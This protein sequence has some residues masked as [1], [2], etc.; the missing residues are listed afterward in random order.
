MSDTEKKS[1]YWQIRVVQIAWLDV[2]FEKPLTE[3]EAVEAFNKDEYYDINDEDIVDRTA[4]SGVLT[5]P[6]TD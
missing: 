6:D 2:S 3:K 5:Y 4:T 1:E